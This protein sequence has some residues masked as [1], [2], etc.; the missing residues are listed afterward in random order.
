MAQPEAE[1]TGEGSWG[2]GRGRDLLGH[3]QGAGL[4]SSLSPLANGMFWLHRKESG[5][6]WLHPG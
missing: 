4:G 3:A 1:G 2:V 6:S 5:G